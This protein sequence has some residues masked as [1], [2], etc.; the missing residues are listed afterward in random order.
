MELGDT[1]GPR[2]FFDVHTVRSVL[3][4]TRSWIA[5]NYWLLHLEQRCIKKSATLGTACS[6]SAKLLTGHDGKHEHGDDAT[7]SKLVTR[8]DHGTLTEQSTT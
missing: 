2:T 6:F 1:H 3:G 4:C 7:T 8:P 5:F